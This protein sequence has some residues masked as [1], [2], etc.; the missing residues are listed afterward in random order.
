L[1]KDSDLKRLS[2]IV[3][4]KIH[5]LFHPDLNI[6]PWHILDAYVPYSIHTDAYSDLDPSTHINSDHDYAW[7]FII[8]LANYN[9][10]TIIFDQISPVIKNTMPWVERTNPPLLDEISEEF[11]EKYLT[12]ESS[13][14]IR[15]LS[16]HDTFPWTEG[17]LSA[18][19]RKRFHCSSNFVKDG[20]KNKKALV[21][22]STIHKDLLR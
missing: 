2:Q 7:T 21:A 10:T 6:G 8:P 13:W 9:S 4:T 11:I 20:L 17:A 1:T 18:T 16:L 19:N 22:W 3:D 15:H 12:H 5:S 14:L